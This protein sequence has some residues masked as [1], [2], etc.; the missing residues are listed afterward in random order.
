MATSDEALMKF[1]AAA[2]SSASGF[3]EAAHDADQVIS[4]IESCRLGESELMGKML[5]VV[6][7]LGYG[8]KRLDLED[9]ADAVNNYRRAVP[10]EQDG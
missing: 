7:T 10:N 5:R 2:R 9:M 6:S 1:L 4:D 3:R 8:I